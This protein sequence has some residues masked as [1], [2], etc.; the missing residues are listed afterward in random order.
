MVYNSKTLPFIAPLKI[1]NESICKSQYILASSSDF[2]KHIDTNRTFGDVIVKKG[3]EYTLE[4]K[5][6]TVLHEG[7]K[8]EN[9]AKFSV[10]HASY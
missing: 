1:Q 3:V 8:V 7:F 10:I 5:G 6:K 9:G 2:G 4:A